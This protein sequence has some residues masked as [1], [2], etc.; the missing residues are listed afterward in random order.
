MSLCYSICSVNVRN[1]NTTTT[2]KI[3]LQSGVVNTKG[4]FSLFI[5]DYDTCCLSLGHFILYKLSMLS[6][7]L[8]S[9][10]TPSIFAVQSHLHF[11]SFVDLV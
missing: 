2:K 6:Y 1:L 3:F 11:S 10:Y 7:S 9:H 4:I 8:V 5:R